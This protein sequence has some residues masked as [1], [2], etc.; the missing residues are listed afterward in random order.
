MGSHWTS[1]SSGESSF[2][3]YTGG[4]RTARFGEPEAV[5]MAI[6]WHTTGKADMDLLS[7]VLYLADYIE[8]SRRL[9]GLSKL[10]KLAYEDL[11][12]F[13]WAAELTIGIWKPGGC[14]SIP[15]PRHVDYL[16]GTK[17]MNPEK[18]IKGGSRLQKA[19]ETGEAEKPRVPADVP[20]ES[21]AGGLY[22]CHSQPRIIVTAFAAS[23]LPCLSSRTSHHAEPP[24]AARSP[25]DLL[26]AGRSTTAGGRRFLH[27]SHHGRVRRRREHRHGDA[28]AGHDAQS[29]AERHEHSR[30]TDGQ[31]LLGH[32]AHQLRL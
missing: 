7:K 12:P 26:R 18:S 4:H 27:L 31:R 15:I 20:T 22:R 8:P 16:K 6:Y 30:D 3:R 5:C 9:P 11:T 13:C 25:A 19:P 29:E 2:P 17:P 28:G 24:Q 23:R 21:P 32:Q 1:W 10:R 14:P